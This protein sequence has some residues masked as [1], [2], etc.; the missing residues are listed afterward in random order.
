MPKAPVQPVLSMH[1][2]Y[3]MFERVYERKYQ[4]IDGLHDILHNG[5]LPL[6]HFP[7]IPLVRVSCGKQVETMEGSYQ[8]IAHNLRG[9]VL[10][11]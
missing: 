5:I 3:E 1:R 11:L 2:R 8:E 7:K 6:G 9:I 4:A 10:K